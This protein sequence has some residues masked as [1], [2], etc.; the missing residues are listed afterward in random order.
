MT[1]SDEWGHIDPSLPPHAPP[2]SDFASTASVLLAYELRGKRRYYDEDELS[3]VNRWA[4]KRGRTAAGVLWVE[5][6]EVGS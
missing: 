3:E 5:G 1:N 2:T 4:L 6:I